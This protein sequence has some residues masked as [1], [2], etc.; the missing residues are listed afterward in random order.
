MRF[1]EQ[2]QNKK[3]P[4]DNIMN[5]IAKTAQGTFNIITIKFYKKKTSFLIFFVILKN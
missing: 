2:L 4:W 3:G 1:K 5:N